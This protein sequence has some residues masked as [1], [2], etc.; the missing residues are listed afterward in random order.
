MPN[1]SLCAHRGALVGGP[2]TKASSSRFWP[3][4]FTGGKHSIALSTADSCSATMLPILYV[5]TYNAFYLAQLK[6]NQIDQ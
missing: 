2:V 3:T 6:V 5:V 1:N 4:A